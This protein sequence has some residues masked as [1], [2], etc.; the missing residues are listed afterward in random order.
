MNKIISFCLCLLILGGCTTS[1]K[2]EQLERKKVALFQK[3]VLSE[4]NQVHDVVLRDSNYEST[5]NNILCAY[6][7]YDGFVYYLN[8]ECSTCIMHFLKFIQFLNNEKSKEKVIVVTLENN[9]EMIEYY[10]EQCKVGYEKILF[11]NNANR[12]MGK[13][14]MEDYNGSVLKYDA[15]VII[16]NFS[17]IDF[18]YQP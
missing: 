13:E 5:H 3:L 6:P 12:Y 4:S 16:N 17:F 18:Y 7:F 1:N 11:L 15:G 8:S 2:E 14:C 9:N 10:M